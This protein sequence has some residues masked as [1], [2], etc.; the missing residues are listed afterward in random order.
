[1]IKKLMHIEYNAKGK[2]FHFLK[3]PP[4]AEGKVLF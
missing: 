3:Q 4:K 1:M 2:A